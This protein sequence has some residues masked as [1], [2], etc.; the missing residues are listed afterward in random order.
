MA[1]ENEL[2]EALVQCQEDKVRSLVNDRIAAGVAAAEIVAECNC[3]M[4]EL[5]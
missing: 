4:T 2:V 5:G 3:G 1:E